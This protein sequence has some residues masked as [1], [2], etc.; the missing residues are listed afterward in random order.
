VVV[1]VVV[2]VAG[3]WCLAW[4]RG[5]VCARVVV[6][7]RGVRVGSGVGAATVGAGRPW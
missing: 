3:W 2:V 7:G 1:V 4:T 6:H 5:S